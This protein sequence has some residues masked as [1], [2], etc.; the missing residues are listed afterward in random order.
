[1]KTL[2]KI[3]YPILAGIILIGVYFFSRDTTISLK[4]VTKLPEDYYMS[5]WQLPDGTKVEDELTKEEYSALAKEGAGSPPN[6]TNDSGAKWLSAFQAKKF[7]T[8]TG[9]L[10]EDTFAEM[11]DQI[12][13]KNKRFKDGYLYLPKDKFSDINSLTLKKDEVVKSNKNTNILISITNAIIT[14][15]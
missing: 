10:E 12:V 4:K 13:V 2:N 6:R 15:K 11:E 5:I 9:D 3:K 8:I 14:I 7:T 1:M